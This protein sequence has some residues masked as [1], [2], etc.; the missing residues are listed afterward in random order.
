[1]NDPHVVELTYIVEHDASVDYS[2]ACSID[3]EEEAFRL[4]IENERVSFQFKEHYPTE[5]AARR[6]VD[7]YVRSW[8]MDSELRQGQV[9]SDYVLTERRLSTATRCLR[10]RLGRIW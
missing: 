6:L 3:H 2:V 1:M 10:H 8:E 5:D 7:R 9:S 4:R